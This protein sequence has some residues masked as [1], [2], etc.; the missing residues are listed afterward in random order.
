[1]AS[2]GHQLE[3][4][5]QCHVAVRVHLQVGQGLRGGL[6][7]RLQRGHGP[8]VSGLVMGGRQ[9]YLGLRARLLARAEDEVGGQCQVREQEDEQHPG[10]GR[11][12]LPPH[13][14]HMGLDHVD[15]CR[16]GGHQTVQREPVEKRHVESACLASEGF[17]VPC[18]V[19][20]RCAASL[21]RSMLSSMTSS[22]TN[23]CA[24]GRRFGSR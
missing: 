8:V 11:S 7:K 1:M 3:Q 22:F 21:L 14:G 15:Q 16:Y 18:C 24:Q 4:A 2:A 23:R 12:R 13:V 19:V 17:N 10:D 5:F 6:A 9:G 20:V